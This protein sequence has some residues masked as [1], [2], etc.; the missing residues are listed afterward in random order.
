MIFFLRAKRINKGDKAL[1]ELAVRKIHC[2]DFE[3]P[4]IVFVCV[5]LYPGKRNSDFP[6]F[7]LEAE[8][9]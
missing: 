9:S 5:L 1:W 7:Q 8:F 4:G 3:S 6:S 2:G